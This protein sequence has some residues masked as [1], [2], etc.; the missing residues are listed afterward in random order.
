MTFENLKLT[1]DAKALRDNFGIIR[2][3]VGSHVQIAPVVKAN[4]Y[5]LG[6][7][8]VVPVVDAAGADAFYVA[9]GAEG[10]AAR[11]HTQKPIFI[12]AGFTNPDELQRLMQSNL[13]PVVNAPEQIE[14]IANISPTCPFSI[15]VDT[16]MNRLGI[17]LS[18]IAGVAVKIKDLNVVQVMSHFASADEEDQELTVVQ[19]ERFAAAHKMLCAGAGRDIPASLANSSGIF[20]SIAYHHQMVRLGMGLYGLNPTPERANPMKPVV[21]LHARVLQ[22]RTAQAGETVGYGATHRFDC[23]TRLITIGGGYAD[24]LIRALSNRGRVFVGDMPCNIV[25]RVSMDLISAALPAGVPEPKLGDWVEIIGP[26]QS[27][28]D[29]AVCAGTIGYEI[30]TQLSHRAERVVVSS[31]HQTVQA[32]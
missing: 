5:G 26:H 16:A 31:E 27:A 13:T 3:R 7:D 18:D 14:M 9:N 10:V 1:I 6:V 28:D 15:H 19:A 12:F 17:A 24:G 4:G 20:R 29:L 25:G 21:A 2:A 23:D 30:L 22:V 8:V 32:A 11:T